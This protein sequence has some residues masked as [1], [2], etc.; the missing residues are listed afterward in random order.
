MTEVDEGPLIQNDLGS[1]KQEYLRIMLV[2]EFFLY[3]Y[4][5]MSVE[6]TLV[7]VYWQLDTFRLASYVTG[8]TIRMGVD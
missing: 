5:L 2:R 6:F 8:Q 1:S 4:F 7:S 3:G